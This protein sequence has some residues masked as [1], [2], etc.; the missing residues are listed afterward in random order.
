MPKILVYGNS[1][2]LKMRPPR[3]QVDER[4]YGEWLALHGAEVI[5]LCRAGVLITEAFR[6]FDDDVLCNFPDAV[7]FNFGVVETSRRRTPRPAW[8]GSVSNT[9]F[10]NHVTGRTYPRYRH[11][12]RARRVAWRAASGLSEGLARLLGFSWSW[13]PSNLFIETQRSM[14]ELLFKETSSVALILGIN[15]CSARVESLLPGSM[16]AI[17]KANRALELMASQYPRARFIDPLAI[18]GAD[19]GMLLPDGVHYSALGHRRIADVLVREISS[20]GPRL[21]LTIS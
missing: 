18:L 13:V 20:Y 19:A 21:S 14:L 10:L 7:V 17:Q 15:P 6:T 16:A 9:V 12:R 2:G 5:N 3:S 1:V 8:V 4:T 11:W